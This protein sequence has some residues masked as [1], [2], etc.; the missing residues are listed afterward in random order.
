[1]SERCDNCYGK[2]YWENGH[3]GDPE[4]CCE[5]HGKGF[6]PDG[7]YVWKRERDLKYSRIF[8]K[9]KEEAREKANME[10][11]EWEKSH[12]RPKE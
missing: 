3:N 1:M 10:I 5:C 4:H 6:F 7:Y 12:P 2:G 9:L 8:D 11:K